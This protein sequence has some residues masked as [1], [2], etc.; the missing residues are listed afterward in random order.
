MSEDDVTV[1]ILIT[2]TLF[3]GRV[4]AGTWEV[5]ELS[6]GSPYV[7]YQWVFDGSSVGHR[8]VTTRPPSTWT[9][10]DSQ[11]SLLHFDYCIVHTGL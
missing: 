11:G 3:M 10:H 5:R 9:T 8:W 1:K 2:H 7:G 6:K 4:V